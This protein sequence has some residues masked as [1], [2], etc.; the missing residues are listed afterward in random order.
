[1]SA[2]RGSWLAWSVWFLSNG[3]LVTVFAIGIARSYLGSGQ[4][5]DVF[6]AVSVL[7]FIPVFSTVGALVASRRPSNPIGWLLSASGLC[8]AVGMLDVLLDRFSSTAAWGNWLD[9]W[10]WGLGLGLAATF[11]LL[12]FPTGRLPSRRWRISGSAGDV[13]RSLRGAFGLVLL[14][15]LASVLSVGLRF[16]HA[17]AQVRE[18]LKW[19]VYATGRR[20]VPNRRLQSRGRHRP[21]TSLGAAKY[22]AGVQGSID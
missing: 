3:T 20:P 22:A 7:V 2:R 10:V 1:M 11:V 21:P 16:W 12:L 6:P 8:Y 17:E 14:G 13:L 9:S 15:A 19:L 4:S 18:Q 5:G